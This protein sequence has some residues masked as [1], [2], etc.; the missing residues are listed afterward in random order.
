MTAAAHRPDELPQRS[1]VPSMTKLDYWLDLLLVVA[2]ALDYSFRFT[3][4]AIHEWIGIGLGVALIVHLT[5]HWDWVLRTTKRIIGSLPGRERLRW[6]VDLLLL[7]VMVFCIASGVLVSR[8]ALPALGIKPV[9]G[10]FWNG[11]HTT[12]ADFTLVLATV[13]VALNWRWIVTVTRRLFRRGAPKTA[14][15]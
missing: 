5:L 3:G 1:R 6:I 10:S 8:S 12:T 14:T 9:S 7:I 15:S 4:L 13:H 2:F 11:L